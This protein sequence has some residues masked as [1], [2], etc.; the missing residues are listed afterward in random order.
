MTLRCMFPL[1]LICFASCSK[2]FVPVQYKFQEQ[3]ITAEH[4]ADER[5]LAAIQPYKDSLDKEMNLVLGFSDT[6]LTKSVP[7]SDL[8]N[9]MCDLMLKK[10]RDYYGKPIDFTFLN[11]GGIRIPNLPA[12]NIT[13]GKIIE[14]MPFENRLGVI[15]VKGVV[16]DSLF[17]HMAIKG[18]WQVSGATYKIGYGETFSENHAFDVVIAGTPLDLEKTYT[19]VASDYLLQGGDN[20][21]MLQNI[22]YIDLKKTLRDALIDGLKEMTLRGEHVKSILENRVQGKKSSN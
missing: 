17:N 12:G 4:K 16:L 6:V 21:V 9:F 20:C 18:G 7:E 5:M 22:P 14:L 2:V 3:K 11:N 10:A 15:E 1:L 8:G 19:V 13:L